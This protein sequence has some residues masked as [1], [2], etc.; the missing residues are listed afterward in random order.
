MT[1]LFQAMQDIKDANV[2]ND[3]FN[4]T[5]LNS[6]FAVET[7]EGFWDGEKD[8]YHENILDAVT[9]NWF[10][11]SDVLAEVMEEINSEAGDW[12]KVITV[13]PIKY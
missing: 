11:L 2:S 1:T 4:E 5:A 10:E 6:K 9:Y 13:S 7:K 3:S 12:F 8:C